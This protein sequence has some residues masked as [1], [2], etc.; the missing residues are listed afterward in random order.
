VQRREQFVLLAEQKLAYSIVG[1]IQ[2]TGL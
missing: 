1:G 2:L